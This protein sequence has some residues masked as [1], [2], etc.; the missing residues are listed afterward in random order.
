SAKIVVGGYLYTTDPKMFLSLD[1]DVFVVGEGEARLPEVV[2]RLRDNKPLDDVPG[3]YFQD[4]GKLRY[5]GPAEQLAM[6]ELPPIDW[7]LADRIDPPISFAD[8]PVQ[9]WVETQRGCVFKCEF[10]SYRTLANPEMMSIDAAAHRIV[11]AGRAAK[12]GYIYLADATATFPRKRWQQVMERVIEQGGSRRP[13]WSYARVTDI[14]DELAAVMSKAGMKH[15]FIGQDSGDQRILD[16]MKKGTRLEHVRPAI[17]ALGKHG[18]KAS[19]SF[20]HGFPGETLESI[21]N[22]RKLIA[23]VND[24]F[25]DRPVVIDYFLNPFIYLAFAAMSRETLEDNPKHKPGYYG[26]E[27]TDRVKVREY[28]KTIITMSKIPHAP[29]ALFLLGAG[30]PVVPGFDMAIHDESYEVFKLAKAYER[31]LTIFLEH[32]QFGVPIDGSELR[33]IKGRLKSAFG[34]KAPRLSP[35]RQLIMTRLVPRLRSEWVTECNGGRTGRL[36]RFCVSLLSRRDLGL[37]LAD[38]IATYRQG[39]PVVLDNPESA[40]E[41]KE[42]NL[43]GRELVDESAARASQKIKILQ[44]GSSVPVQLTKG[45]GA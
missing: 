25:K 39:Y 24:D 13:I 34:R 32:E 23:T 9:A 36:T 3:I 27:V 8:A 31:G 20:I 15:V 14:N 35:M 37:S 17:E 11:E 43:L 1:A 10:C 42:L 5:T 4:E 26:D 6:S 40:N 22:T 41:I 45:R 33:E 38:T 44:D 7:S 21:E 28:F 19:L 29:L 30:N 16:A 18:M 12:N 2:I